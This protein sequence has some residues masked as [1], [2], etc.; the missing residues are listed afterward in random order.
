MFTEALANP[1][2]NTI[3]SCVNG[4]IAVNKQP[5]HSSLLIPPVGEVKELPFQNIAD[6]NHADLPIWQEILSGQFDPDGLKPEVFIIGVGN[7]QSFLSPTVLAPFYQA[8]IGVECMTSAAAARSYNVLISE[9]RRVLTLI[10][11]PDEHN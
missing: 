11:L 2:Q 7:R 1:A 3:T 5:F 4:T 8:G 6:L 10:L 9:D